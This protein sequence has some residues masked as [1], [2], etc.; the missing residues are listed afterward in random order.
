MSRLLDSEK[1]ANLCIQPRKTALSSFGTCERQAHNEN[2]PTS[3][4]LSMLLSYI[5]TNRN[6][7]LVISKETSAFGISPLIAALVN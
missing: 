3:Q 4:L 6:S 7:Y 1:T 5:P 2:S